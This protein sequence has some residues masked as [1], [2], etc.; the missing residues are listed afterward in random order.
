MND[1]KFG[2]SDEISNDENSNE[3]IT[4]KEL[5]NYFDDIN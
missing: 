3:N 5:N 2:F 1:E 4:T